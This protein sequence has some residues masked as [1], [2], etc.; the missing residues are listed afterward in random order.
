MYYVYVLKS[1]HFDTIY[2]GS[3][4]DLKN[5]LKSHNSGQSKHTS[6]YKPW[7]IVWYSAYKNKQLA[8]NFEKYLKTASGKAFMRKRLID[9]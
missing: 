2:I 6:K 8:L 3:T 4:N 7:E 5:R 9:I 1:T